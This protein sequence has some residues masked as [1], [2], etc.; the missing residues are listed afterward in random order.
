MLSVW[1]S[2]IQR[3]DHQGNKQGAFGQIPTSGIFTALGISTTAHDSLEKSHPRIQ[4]SFIV[5]KVRKGTDLSR[6]FRHACSAPFHVHSQINSLHQILNH[7]K[8]HLVSLLSLRLGYFY[9]HSN[10]PSYII[11]PLPSNLPQL[12]LPLL[13]THRQNLPIR[14]PRHTCDPS[15]R[16]RTRGPVPIHSTSRQMHQPQRI[17]LPATSQTQDLSIWREL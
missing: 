15:Q 3:A 6:A 16:R 2:L 14:R 10:P 11:H 17:P 7:F 1:E 12:H 9:G 5:L 8:S 13:I 4:P